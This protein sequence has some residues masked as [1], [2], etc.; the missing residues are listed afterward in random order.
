[1]K[2]LLETLLELLDHE[3]GQV[4]HYT[5]KMLLE[6]GESKKSVILKLVKKLDD[7]IAAV[8]EEVKTALG[9]IAGENQKVFKISRS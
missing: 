5:V 9:R 4:R 8:R 7:P 1:M 6:L 2:S 3:S